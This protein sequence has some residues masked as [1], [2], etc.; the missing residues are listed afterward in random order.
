MDAIRYYR[1]TGQLEHTACDMCVRAYDLFDM[2]YR[3][4]P[5]DADYCQVCGE[6]SVDTELSY[7]TMTFEPVS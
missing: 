4:E 1:V 3:A 5:V 7:A 6:G 2:D